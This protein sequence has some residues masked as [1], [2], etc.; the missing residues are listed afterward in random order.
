MAVDQPTSYAFP[1]ADAL[2]DALKL[3]DDAI[4]KAAL[5]NTA[6]RLHNAGLPAKGV[7]VF[8]TDVGMARSLMALPGV[9]DAPGDGAFVVAPVDKDAL[10]I[11]HADDPKDIAAL[12]DAGADEVFVDTGTIAPQVK[13]QWGGADKVLE[14]IGTTTLEDSLQCAKEPGLVCMT[15][16]VGN[17]WSLDNFSPMEAIPTAVCLTTYDGE[18]ADFMRTPLEELAGRVAAGT[19]HIQ[20]GRTFPLDEIA[21]HVRKTVAHAVSGTA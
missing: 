10:I 7:A 14:L 21:E 19:L 5:A 16:I 6:Q 15:G 11:G 3:D 20:I 2:H 13:E 12:R 1:S 17:K 9:W 8:T 4:W 18:S